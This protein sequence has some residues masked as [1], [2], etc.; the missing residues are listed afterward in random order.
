MELAK[1]GLGVSGGD[2]AL[3][4]T[5]RRLRQP[6]LKHVLHTTA[7]GRATFSRRGLQPAPDEFE[8][9]QVTGPADERL[10]VS[11][12]YAWRLLH[13]LQPPALAT[14]ERP[15]A[16][17]THS[18]ILPTVLYG[19]RLAQR[20]GLPWLAWSHMV[21]PDLSRGY[22]GQFTG[23]RH[24]PSYAFAVSSLTQ[25]LSFRLMGRR[26]ARVLT[27]NTFT[28]Q[29]LKRRGVPGDRIT[30]IPYGADHLIQSKT[31]DRSDRTYTAVFVGR[32]HDQ[33][34]VMDLPAIWAR[35]RT[36]LPDAR[37]A[38]VGDG[39]P[40]ITASLEA[41]LADRGVA[42]AVDLL[43]F[44]DDEAKIDVLRS[45]GVLLFPSYYESWGIVALEALCQERPVV[46]YDLPVYDGLFDAGIVRAPVGDTAAL[47]RTVA[48]LAADPARGR[49]L[50]REGRE[51]VAKLR[52]ADAANQ[53]VEEV[54]NAISR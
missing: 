28:E 9:R 49:T 53:V 19:Y 47:A 24:L 29:Q 14:E 33:K 7:S 32:F 48:D 23:T 25:A 44:L 3:L 18:D 52:W 22:Q 6:P 50:G 38:I 1:I 41:A 37:L 15:A 35:V 4:E 17:L 34:G 39:P 2:V 11:A 10:G 12:A 40:N 42:D 54:Q 43:G 20:N 21:L 36:A 16:V 45:A 5:L 30:V 46:A 13:G 27:I 31:S 51:A 8:Y 26:A